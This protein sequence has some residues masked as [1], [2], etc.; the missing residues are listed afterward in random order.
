MSELVTFG[1]LMLRLSPQG[2]YA[3]LQNENLLATYGGGEANVAVS[4]SNYGV[5]AAFVTKLPENPIGDGAIRVLRSFGVDTKHIL[6][7]GRRMGVYFVERGASQ[8]P[9][10]VIYDRENSAIA[11]SRPEEY[12]W[13]D[14]L[15]GCRWFHFTGITPA[16]G[17]N[18]ASA[19]LDACRTA[20]KKG[21]VVSCDL[22]YRSKLWS[23]EEAGRVMAELMPYVDVC[24]ANEEDAAKVFGI[25]PGNSN[26]D[27]GILSR[28]GYI[29]V[30]KKLKQRFGFKQVAI[31]LRQSHSSSDNGWSA[32]LYDGEKAFF[33]DSY[34]IHIV[35]RV[36][37]GDSF[38]GA[39]IYALMR[40]YSPQ[41]AINFAAAASCLKHSYE[42]DFNMA[43]VSDVLN[44]LKSGGN[45]RIQR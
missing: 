27:H 28:E 13:D 34:S 35:D 31:T 22:N 12:N 30:A 6:R 10:R 24:I 4:A 32:M 5:D 3:L 20:R 33:S 39:L 42:G 41:E 7:G 43:S 21:I 38:G 1:E 40:S 2:Y 36:G 45:G 19:V 17:K 29:D 26:I 25:H 37:G 14:I 23:P 44:L 18:L 11:E 8:R 15:D 16:L 9:S